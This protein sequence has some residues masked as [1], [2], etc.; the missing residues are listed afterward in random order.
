MNYAT[1]ELKTATE[2]LE[3]MSG[4][5]VKNLMPTYSMV[6]KIVRMTQEL[7]IG[8]FVSFPA[9]I[10]RNSSKLV[11]F[12]ARALTSSNPLIRQMGAHFLIGAS[13]VFGGIGYVAS[14]GAERV[15]R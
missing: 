2:M 5:M 9:E 15:C 10:L 7:P 3:E 1:G 12:G 6:P 8:N 14:K 11:L 4:N 13:G